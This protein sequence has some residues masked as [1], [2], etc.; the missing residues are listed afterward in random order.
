MVIQGD[1][2]KSEDAQRVVGRV[3]EKWQRIDILVNN[4]GSPKTDLCRR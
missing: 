1:V 4:A 2:S 3:L